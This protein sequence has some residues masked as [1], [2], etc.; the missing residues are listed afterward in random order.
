MGGRW[1]TLGNSDLVRRLWNSFGRCARIELLDFNAL[2]ERDPASASWWW[3]EAE[4][5]R[6]WWGL[7]AES[8]RL[9]VEGGAES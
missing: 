2:I 1:W 9:E 6:W 3:L 7:E 5:A 8:C 4:G